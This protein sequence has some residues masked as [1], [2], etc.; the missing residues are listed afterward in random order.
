MIVDGAIPFKFTLDKLDANDTESK[1]CQWEFISKNNRH[2][3]F[4]VSACDTEMRFKV[5]RDN[6][7][8]NQYL[9]SVL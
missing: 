2:L 5:Q 4:G 7:I 3:V 6:S 1:N 8:F 9:R